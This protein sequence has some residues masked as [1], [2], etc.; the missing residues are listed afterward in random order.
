M[1]GWWAKFW[2]LMDSESV[3]PFV[4]I[5]YIAL[6]LWGIYATIWAQPINVVD[7]I[8]GHTVYN[9]WVWIQIP[10]TLSVMTGLALRQ[11]KAVAHEMSDRQLFRD[12]MGL[13]MQVG[14]HSC[15]FFVLLTFEI[16]AVAGG[17]WGDG[18]FSIFAIAPYVLGCLFL[19]LQTG[20]K[21]VFAL[22]REGKR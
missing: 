14:G 10:A 2:V 13:W 22:V 4:W 12:Y 1:K 21:A 19:M 17:H 20:R 7:Q 5:Y 3:L 18:A 8:M 9:A 15:M 16:A 6:L 11:D